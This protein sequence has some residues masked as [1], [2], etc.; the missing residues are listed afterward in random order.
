MQKGQFLEL[1]N[2][3][4][5]NKSVQNTSPSRTSNS[6]ECEMDTQSSDNTN[7]QDSSKIGAQCN[8]ND[9]VT[10]TTPSSNTSTLTGTTSYRDG[11]AEEQFFLKLLNDPMVERLLTQHV[12]HM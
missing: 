3:V 11:N 7:V 8:D 6:E 9:S 4:E 1:C 12:P 2:I 10:G 5:T